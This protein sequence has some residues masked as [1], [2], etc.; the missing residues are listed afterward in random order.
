MVA[1]LMLHASM[2]RL[3]LTIVLVKLAIRALASTVLVSV[4]N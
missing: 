2:S 4:I 3:G 1:T